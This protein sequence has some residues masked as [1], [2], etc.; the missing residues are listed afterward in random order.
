MFPDAID[1]LEGRITVLDCSLDF[2]EMQKRVYVEALAS[3]LGEIWGDS[4]LDDS[5]RDRVADNYLT[6]LMENFSVELCTYGFICAIRT[7]DLV[8]NTDTD[9]FDKFFEHVQKYIG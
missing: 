2:D 8:F 9:A 7:H 5:E 4:E 6:F 3:A 1:V